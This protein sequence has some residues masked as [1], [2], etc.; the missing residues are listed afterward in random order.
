MAT[1]HA[2]SPVLRL[3]A[4]MRP[5]G[6]FTIGSPCTCGPR[7]GTTPGGVGG[8]HKLCQWALETYYHFDIDS[9]VAVA[10]LLHVVST[11]PVIVTGAALMLR[12]GLNW[13]ELKRETAADET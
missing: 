6:G 11:L 7:P 3:S 13:R 10:V 1:I 8:F 9:S 5:Y 4:V 12:E 2:S